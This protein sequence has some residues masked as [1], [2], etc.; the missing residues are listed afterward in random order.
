MGAAQHAIVE[1]KFYAINA[2]K[3]AQKRLF[4]CVNFI[5]GPILAAY[6]LTDGTG[7]ALKLDEARPFLVHRA[8]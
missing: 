7:L 1:G 3:A 5:D 6:L 8:Q 2:K 4:S